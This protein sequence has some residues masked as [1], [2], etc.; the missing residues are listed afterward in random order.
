MSAIKAYVPDVKFVKGYLYMALP[1]ILQSLISASVKLVDNIMV[2]SVGGS[3]MGAVGT[4][5]KV[6]FIPELAFVGVL[7]GFGMF[8]SQYFGDGNTERVKQT[9]RAKVVGTLIFSCIAIIISI[10]FMDQIIGIFIDTAETTEYA[11]TY[12]TYMLPYFLALGFAMSY[13]FTYREVGYTKIVIIAS[14]SAIATNTVLNYLLIGG[15]FGFPKW[16][17][18]GAA[19]ATVIAR[20]VEALILIIYARI[21]NLMFYSKFKDMLKIDR[22]LLSA[23]KGKVLFMLSNEVAYA[24]VMNVVYYAY[25][26]RGDDKLAAISIADTVNQFIFAFFS[27]VSIVVTLQVG[28]V[29]GEGDLK[30]ANNNA[31][32][33]LTTSVLLAM[34]VGLIGFIIAPIIVNIPLYDISE[35]TRVLAM[36]LVFIDAASVP[37]FTA[38]FCF[39]FI[40]R[41]GGDTLSMA[42]MD[43]G[44]VLIVTMPVFWFMAEYTHLSLLEMKLV[45]SAL[46]ILKLTFGII[47]F[48]RRIWL[49]KIV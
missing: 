16:G 31:N 20:T 49:R 14:L 21:K 22:E 45:Y 6:I 3:A 44:F 34:V 25:A 10:I 28:K 19:I 11:K 17:V 39:Y 9:L 32:K 13:S 42:M 46:E 8:T 7:A 12:Y 47:N 27:G 33:T 1:L 30:A 15:N 4:V 36:R 18:K 5:N 37:L 48:K 40:F 35:E 43:L 26:T 23:A 2:G 24:V 29:L 41:S 38:C